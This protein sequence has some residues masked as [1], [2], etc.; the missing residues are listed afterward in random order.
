MQLR[1]PAIIQAYETQGLPTKTD[2]DPDVLMH[3]ILSD[4]KRHSNS[5]NLIVV[6]DVG[7]C[8]VKGFTLD[9]IR[10]LLN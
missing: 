7:N 6:K 3:Y 9:E 4:K 10:A 8:E 5:V 2:V 1:L